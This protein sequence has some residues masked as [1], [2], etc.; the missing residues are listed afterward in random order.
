MLLPVVSAQA[1]Q[2]DGDVSGPV[3]AEASPQ[4]FATMCALYAAGMDLGS[5]SVNA[6]PA[7]TEVRSRLLQVHGPA[8]DALR[9]YYRAHALGT[10]SATLSRYITFAIVAGPP[11]RFA[12]TV[13]RADLPPDALQL[14][15]FSQ[16]LANF[17]KEAQIEDLWRLVQPEYEKGVLSL[18]EPLGRIVLTGTGYLRQLI[19]QGTGT[20]TAYPEPLVGG[21]TQ[22]RNAGNQYAIIVDP[23]NDSF[24]AM[25][26]AFLH[27]LL[28]PL[29]VR[30][31]DQIRVA[32]PL[33]LTGATA[34]RLP[35]EFRDDFSDYFTECLV[36]AVELKLRRLAPDKLGQELNRADSDGFVL[37]RPLMAALAKFEASE[38]PMSQYF[39]ELIRSID[40]NAE[41]KRLQTVAFAPASNELGIEAAQGEHGDGGTSPAAV[42]TALTEGERQIAA[43]DPAAAAAAFQRVLTMQP[44]N[45]RALYGLAVASLLQRDAVHARELFQQVV[46]G[47]AS[48]ASDPVALAW[49]HIYL[50]RMHDLDGDRDQA[51][52]DYRAAIAVS[53]VPDDARSAAQRGIDRTY[54]LAVPNPS[55]G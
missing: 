39:P 5:P 35:L 11:P 54:Q 49:S 51:L 2:A 22:F 32:E 19:R 26:H 55:P 28:D 18:R 43:Q 6:D 14:D 37:I 47:S 34:P 24:D 17:Y 15:G 27:F 10:P 50:G 42:N 23:S 12:P 4:L 25:R 29:P 46:D 16:I 45:P 3:Q 8:T 52:A 33:F 7:F 21:Q 13:G 44:G 41:R 40:V 20:F 53:G 1:A 36:R 31:H 48:A 9:D 30:Y 38:P